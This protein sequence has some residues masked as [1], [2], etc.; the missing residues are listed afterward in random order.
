MVKVKIKT[1]FVAPYAAMENLIEECG[2]ID[3]EL[4][5]LVRVGNL[6]DGVAVAKEMNG[7]GIDVIISRG[8]TAKM[9]EEVVDIPVVD[10]HVSGY[11]M[12]R[13]LTLANDFPTKK[14]IVG[15]SNFTS[16]AK[17]IIDLSDIDVDIFTINNDQEIE[18]L[19][20]RLKNEG[21]QL[22]MG[23]VI[24]VQAV[25]KIGLH[26]ILIQSGREAIFEAFKE[27]KSIHKLTV[28]NR[29]ELERLKA[30]LT[31][32]AGDLMVLSNRGD[33]VYEQWNS[34][35][36]RPV[37]FP[38]IEW[39][40]S[41][42][43]P[44]NK[45]ISHVTDEKGAELKIT[46]S[47]IHV[48]EAVYLVCEIAAQEA[49]HHNLGKLQKE[50]LHSLPNIIHRSQSM[51]ASLGII[52]RSLAHKH[53]ILI[54]EKGTG[55]EW[56]ARYIHYQQF[57][58]SGFFAIAMASDFLEMWV[59][60]IDQDVKTIFIRKIEQLDE[61]QQAS[62]LK[63]MKALKSKGMTIILS[64]SH[65]HPSL[66]DFLYGDDLIRVHIP[67]L[68]ERKEDIGELAT[69]FIA[70]FNQ[71]LGT[72]PIKIKEKGIELLKN[73]SWPGN[74]AELKALIKDAIFAENGYVIDEGLIA[75]LLKRK[76]AEDVKGQSALLQGSLEEIEQKIIE[77]V[78]EEENFNQTKAAKRLNINRSTLWRK[79]KK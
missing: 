72:S 33:I 39:L 28:K 7:Q 42:E 65:D 13:T 20:Q 79:L 21:Y 46:T 17:A 6:Q 62:F 2:K 26:G 12:L 70:Y 66:T 40:V 76:M 3:T 56:M 61:R 73:Y 34:F 54:G 51:N 1:L 27:A 36:S 49:D 77:A 31:K 15:F 9:I 14:A 10:V 23:D 75:K 53:F 16:G 35:S 30:V 57:H 58:G 19:V 74:V 64:V 38:Q 37:S 29:L 48:E 8:G 32:T 78:L 50:V 59:E 11:D 68:T 43:Y 24:T 44:K 5:V 47:M 25:S 60:E 71:T 45:T 4:D 69:Y 67:A 18:P 52:D 41:L 22:I 63:I 55:K